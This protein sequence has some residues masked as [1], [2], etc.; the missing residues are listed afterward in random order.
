MENINI[1]NITIKNI[2]GFGDPA[3]SLN[4]DLNSNKV[5]IL[6]APNGFGKS[7]IA[8]AFNSLK[9]K[10]LD[11]PSEYFHNKTDTLSSEL[12]ITLG[13]EVLIANKHQNSITPNLIC[14]VIK[15]NIDVETIQ[16]NMGRFTSVSA[17]I[18]IPPIEVISKVPE[19]TTTS[20]S[21]TELRKEF[22]KNGKVLDNLA[23]LFTSRKFLCNISD[24]FSSLDIFL[25]AKKRHDILLEVVSK[26][27]MINGTADFIK[28][29]IQDSIYDNLF[30]QEN[31]K[32]ILEINSPFIDRK[33]KFEKFSFLFQIIE[34]W[35]L[36]H[37]EIKQ[38]NSRAEYELFLE[39]F[40]KDLSLLDT[41][42]K[43]IHA[44]EDKGRLL[45]MYPKADEI[46]NG[47]R[48]VLTFVT[49]LIAFKSSIKP[50]KKHL[51]I[52]DEVFDYLD[53]ANIIVGQYYLSKFLDLYKGQI[54]LCLLTH[55][56][57]K[58]FRSY[59]FN[60]KMV[61]NIYLK[62]VIPKASEAM[63]AYITFRESLDKKNDQ[64][65]KELYNDL[66][67]DLFHY[68]PV[69]VDYSE[70]IKKYSNDYKLKNSWGKTKIFHDY[71]IQETNKYIN[72][73]EMYDPYAVAM[74]LRIKIEKLVY[75]KLESEEQKK[76][77]I[78]THMTK[79]KFEYAENEGICILDVYN[80]VN[81][82]HNEAD[83]IKFNNETNTFVETPM[84]YKLQN[85]V[86]KGILKQIFQA[87]T[88]V[89]LSSSSIE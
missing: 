86:I 61:N 28:N 47:Q 66:S 45:V 29:K 54:Y 80:I 46:S 12:S 6:Y 23:D 89:S 42:W 2:K 57:S 71:L 30:T 83:H 51:L 44:I 85:I 52:I 31:C 40:N 16:H 56:N 55:L 4:V 21:V 82:I 11:V 17:Y 1:K 26:I 78:N 72:D 9:A 19:S 3:V 48:D 24:C 13:E 79:N 53:D 32:E 65:Q 74:T 77:F 8:A 63:L 73:E 67:R 36:H 87:N 34:W 50:N 38:S 39:R 49:Q 81:A 33:T 41:T 18:S 84:V 20:Y 75:E 64:A 58:S 43:D 25:R 7:S 68:N 59:I 88:E 69:V 14:K 60:T 10:S 70:R 15:S 62:H 27:N 5:N 76:A 37:R 22:G 35:H